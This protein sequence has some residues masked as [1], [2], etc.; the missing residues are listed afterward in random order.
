[1]KRYAL[2]AILASL[3]FAPMSGASIITPQANSG[4][5]A[6]GWTSVLDCDLTAQPTQTISVDGNVTVCGVTAV[7]INSAS[8]ASPMVLTNGTGLVVTP[9]AAADYFGTTRTAPA[10]TFN[11]AALYSKFD[12][13]TPLRVTVYATDNVATANYDESV[14]Y[15]ENPATTGGSAHW[16]CKRGFD[17]NVGSTQIECSQNL[18]ANSDAPISYASAYTNN[19]VRFVF[20][21]GLLAQRWNM[22]NLVWGGSFPADN[23]FTAG[24]LGQFSSSSTTSEEPYGAP[25]A[26][27]LILGAIRAG[28]GHAGF[29]VT[30]KYVK[31]EVHK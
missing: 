16:G 10:L 20:P 14:I 2:V 1:M 18:N 7:K 3:I 22:T 4:G 27:D 21:G 17:G 28:G 11:I 25:S 19:T 15:V 31:I 26:Y 12:L 5:A 8:D 24:F 9:V 6:A 29:A 13:T 30:F 23:A